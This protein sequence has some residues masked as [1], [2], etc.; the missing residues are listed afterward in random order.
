[1]LALLQEPIEDCDFADRD[2]DDQC[3]DET[4]AEAQSALASL[5]EPE[6]HP[7]G[8]EFDG[9]AV[10]QPD[11]LSRFM[12]YGDECVRAGGQHKSFGSI[13]G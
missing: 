10:S 8:A 7:H 5:P 1:M 13:K 6:P 4:F 11:G 12:I 3:P 9:I 2:R